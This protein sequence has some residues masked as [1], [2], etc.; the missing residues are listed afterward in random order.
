MSLPN[1][2]TPESAY[3]LAGSQQGDERESA[4][5]RVGCTHRRKLEALGLLPADSAEPGMSDTEM[6]DLLEHECLTAGWDDPHFVVARPPHWWSIN[7]QVSTHHRLRDAIRAA[8]RK[9]PKR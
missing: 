9:G 7:S 5:P 1:K 3:N 6:L 2:P 4:E 8:R